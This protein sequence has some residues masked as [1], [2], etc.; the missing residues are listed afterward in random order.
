MLVLL[1]A[2][3]PDLVIFAVF[4][5]FAGMYGRSE[6]LRRRLR[7]QAYGALLVLSGVGVGVTLSALHA[8]PWALV[9]IEAFLAAVGSLVAD[10]AGLR[11]V[12]PFF[13]IFALGA[14]AS[15]P[16]LVA[17]WIAIAISVGS[18][19]LA[20]LIGVIGALR[21]ATAEAQGDRVLSPDRPQSQEARLR[22]AV[23][24]AVAVGLSGGIA[25]SFGTDHAAWAMAAAAVPLAG[26][27]VPSRLYRGVQRIL[28]T[29][30]GLALTGAILLPDPGP[31]LLVVAI[32]VLQFPSEL[33]MGRNYGLALVFFTPLIMLMTQLAH[34][35]PRSMLIADRAVETLLG[36]G[37][38]IA[39][40]LVSYLVPRRRARVRSGTE[41]G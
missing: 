38:G 13:G 21:G 34:P 18:A 10:R 2:G 17:P 30:L 12:G 16:P 36:A 9:T 15:I 7:H 20:I 22:H 11:P 31:M 5:G 32:V 14:C 35:V 28:G 3:R 33:L 4:G 23:A 26:T 39:V 41:P 25:L 24:Y 1:A 27:D 37:V 19:L 40:V 29:F 8:A 6:P